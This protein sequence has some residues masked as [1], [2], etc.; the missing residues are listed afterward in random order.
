MRDGDAAQRKEHGAWAG[1]QFSSAVAR[2]EEAPDDS[3]VSAPVEEIGR[4]KLT[5][6]N[7]VRARIGIFVNLPRARTVT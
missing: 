7:A 2:S 5:A 4:P 3:G 6:A 1:E